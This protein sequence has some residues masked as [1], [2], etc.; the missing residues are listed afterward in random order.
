[1]LEN[2]E[3]PLEEIKEIQS[4]CGKI[5]L[6]VA[7]MCFGIGTSRLYKILVESDKKELE[8]EEKVD[9]PSGDRPATVVCKSL[10]TFSI[11]I[12]KSAVSSLVGV[13]TFSSNSSSSDSTASFHILYN[14]L[15]PIPNHFLA[16]VGDILPRKDCI[17]SISSGDSTFF[18]SMLYILYMVYVQM[19]LV[20]KYQHWYKTG[21]ILVRN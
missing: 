3:L 4:L 16:A 21:T 2:K 5:S 12:A 9:A 7:R 18:S 1:M 13:S 10:Y 8:E 6:S 11:D 19:E 17:S 15:V 14:L 20:S